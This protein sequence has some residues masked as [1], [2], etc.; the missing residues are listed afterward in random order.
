MRRWIQHTVVS[1]ALFLSLAG[2]A[3]LLPPAQADKAPAGKYPIVEKLTHKGYTETI[4]GTKVTF[5]MVPI[6]GR[7]LPARQPNPEKGRSADEGPQHPVQLK[8]FWMG[9]CEVTWDE[10][11]SCWRRPN[12]HQGGR[13]T[14]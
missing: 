5:D 6:P 9:K 13:L 8:G 11:D 14:P 7:H 2:V 1:L 10:F 4:P 12:R 3:G